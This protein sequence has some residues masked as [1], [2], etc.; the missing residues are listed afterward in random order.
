MN[1]LSSAGRRGQA[2]RRGREVDVFHRIRV[3]WLPPTSGVPVEREG[4][5][6]PGRLEF[7]DIEKQ[8]RGRTQTTT[9]KGKVN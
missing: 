8:R 1:D 5:S 2:M 9:V 6:A 3:Y 4:R 7:R